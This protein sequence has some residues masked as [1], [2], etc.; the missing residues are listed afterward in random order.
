M[1]KLACGC[2]VSFSAKRTLPDGRV[3]YAKHYGLKCWPFVTH[4]K[5]C[6]HRKMAQAVVP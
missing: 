3:L 5:N 6:P 2:P 4:T 1:A